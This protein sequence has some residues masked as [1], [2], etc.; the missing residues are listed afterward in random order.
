MMIGKIAALRESDDLPFL[1]TDSN[2]RNHG[3]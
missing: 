2:A 3:G 1:A